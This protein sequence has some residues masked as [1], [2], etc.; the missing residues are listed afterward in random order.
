MKVIY[1]EDYAPLINYIDAYV[2]LDTGYE[3]LLITT[4]YTSN[5]QKRI[6][7]V[8][9]IP[10][11][12]NKNAYNDLLDEIKPLAVELLKHHT[13]DDGRGYL[14]EDGEDIKDEIGRLIHEW[15][16]DEDGIVYIVGADREDVHYYYSPWGISP[17]KLREIARG[18]VDHDGN[19]I[20]YFDNDA[21]NYEIASMELIGEAIYNMNVEQACDYLSHIYSIYKEDGFASDFE[22]VLLPFLEEEGYIEFID[23]EYYLTDTEDDEENHI[24][25]EWK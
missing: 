17:S 20:L 8:W 5:V 9:S 10:T 2:Y 25:L 4:Y 23:G 22:D 6:D 1:E 16:E 7:F 11:R 19:Y 15:K 14:D 13:I 3:R 24:P 21:E 18:K 12:F